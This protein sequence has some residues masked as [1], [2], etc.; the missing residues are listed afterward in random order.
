M[1][2]ESLTLAEVASVYNGKAGRCACGCAGTHSYASSH[3]ALASKS[4]GYDVK[5]EE[6]SD[7]KVLN[8]FKKLKAHAD[9]VEDLGD[10]YSLDLGTRTYVVYTT[11]H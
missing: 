8:V 9:L 11:K 5:P 10:C 3:V 6:V 1:S 7:T 2:F 4:R